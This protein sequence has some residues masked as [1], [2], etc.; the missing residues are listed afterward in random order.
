MG[1]KSLPGVSRGIP[2]SPHIGPCNTFIH[3]FPYS[4]DRNTAPPACQAL[5][6]RTCILL[7]RGAECNTEAL[8]SQTE[9]HL[10]RMGAR[11]PEY[12]RDTNPAPN[13]DTHS[14]GGG[15]QAP[16]AP[17]TCGML[18][19]WELGAQGGIGWEQDRQAFQD[20]GQGCTGREDAIL[21]GA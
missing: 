15:R 3:S 21:P 1:V 5:P 16:R 7:G 4:T 2:H 19:R 12:K 17:S 8:V 14:P 18:S 9:D 13:S 20:R 6:S 10:H 11:C